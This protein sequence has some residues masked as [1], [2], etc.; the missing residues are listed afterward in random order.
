MAASPTE[1]VDAAVKAMSP[2]TRLFFFS[3]VLSPTG[4]V[5]PA[6]EL[7]AEARRRGIITVVDG[8]NRRR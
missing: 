1:I 8:A 6:A 3:H 7:C 2:R 4:L 5:L